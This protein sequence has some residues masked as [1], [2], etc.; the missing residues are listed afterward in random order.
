MAFLLKKR[1]RLL[2][3]RGNLTLARCQMVSF[4]WL[5]VEMVADSFK[6]FSLK[7][8]MKVVRYL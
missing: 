4:M 6:L 8:K 1:K 5:D 2:G 3:L 7:M